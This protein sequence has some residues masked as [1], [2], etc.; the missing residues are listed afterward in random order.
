MRWKCSRRLAAFRDLFPDDPAFVDERLRRIAHGKDQR[1]SRSRSGSGT[2]SRSRAIRSSRTT[3]RPYPLMSLAQRTPSAF[4]IAARPVPRAAAAT[5]KS[6]S[7][8]RRDRPDP[9]ATTASPADPVPRRRAR[10]APRQQ[11]AIPGPHA[12]TRLRMRGRSPNERS[13]KTPWIKAKAASLSRIAGSRGRSPRFAETRNPACFKRYAQQHAAT[14]SP[15]MKMFFIS[16][17]L[18]CGTLCLVLHTSSPSPACSA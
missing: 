11:P 16:F 3:D 2:A 7:R 18:D 9:L 6:S 12:T 5:K 14:P 1:R 8:H 10:N 15:D 4:R 17:V 13:P